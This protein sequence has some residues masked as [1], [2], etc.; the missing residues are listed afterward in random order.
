ML[1]GYLS[2]SRVGTEALALR[3]GVPRDKIVTI[4]NGIDAGALI[5]SRTEG[6]R[7][8]LRAEWA[9][10]A[11]GLVAVV[12]ANIHAAK[13]HEDLVRAAR[14]CQRDD[15]VFVLAGEDRSDG[16]VPAMVA[17]AGLTAR[18]RFL[19]LR[20]DIADVLAASDVLIL[21]SHWEGMSNA[22]MEGMA[23]GL[24][25]IAT[26]VGAA[27]E[28]FDEGRAGVLVP[29]RD[30]TSLLIALYR[31]ADDPGERERIGTAARERIGEHFTIDRMTN[32][33][34][35]FYQQLALARTSAQ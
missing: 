27:A 25:C 19:G 11:Q 15:I 4:P 20:R 1:D 8:R 9:V 30:P 14:D 10:P 31:L 2:N 16:R 5:R 23:S 21:P 6:A 24:P 3:A 28:L 22:L 17:S 33:Y 12:V 26:D 34:T 32:L 18:F 35:A 13:G 7:S 29:P